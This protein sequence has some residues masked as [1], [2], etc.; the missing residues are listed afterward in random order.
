MTRIDLAALAEITPH[1]RTAYQEA[2]VSARDV[3]AGFG[4]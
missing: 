1:A 3:L 4:I 2:F